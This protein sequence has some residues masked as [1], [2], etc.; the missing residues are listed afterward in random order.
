MTRPSSRCRPH[1]LGLAYPLDGLRD[2]VAT[3]GCATAKDMIF[4]A[5]R[6]RPRKRCAS[7]SST[8]SSPILRPRPGLCAEIAEGAPLT[9]THAKR[10]VDLIAGQA[11]R[12]VSAKWQHS[13]HACFD[14]E[15]YPEGQKA[16]LE[17]RKPVF[18]GR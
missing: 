9:I 10:A 5:R 13:P 15:D 14:S 4:T 12:Y 3:V 18:R 2:L 16:F 1:R 17:K 6:S 8:G 7:A 11:R